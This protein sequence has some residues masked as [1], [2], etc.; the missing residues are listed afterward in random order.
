MGIGQHGTALPLRQ[1]LDMA[2]QE[3]QI[4]LDGGERRAQFV[5]GVGHEAALGLGGAFQR[6]EHLIERLHNLRQFVAPARVLHALAQV[7]QA[8]TS[9]SGGGDGARRGHQVRQRMQH[10]RGDQPTCKQRSRQG[11]GSR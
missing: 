4:A 8:R 5:R 10:T 7:A 1:L 3:G 11:G 6:R 9:C 2:L